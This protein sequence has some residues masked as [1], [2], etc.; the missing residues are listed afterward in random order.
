M[1][2]IKRICAI[3]GAV[4]LMILYLLTIVFA[5]IQSPW[6]MELLKITIGLTI[7]IPVL[8]WIG[9]AAFR[10]IA[11]QRQS[12]LDASLGDDSTNGR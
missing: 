6:S 3:A 10:S 8:L 4:L 7:L 5:L 11:A 1:K 12:N 9:I 2:N